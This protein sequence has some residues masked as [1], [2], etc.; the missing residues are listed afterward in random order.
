MDACAA[1]VFPCSQTTIRFI[2]VSSSLPLP[3]LL[4]AVCQVLS[5]FC[6]LSGH[7]LSSV[8][9]PPKHTHKRSEARRTTHTERERERERESQSFSSSFCAFWILTLQ[10]L[11]SVLQSQLNMWTQ[12]SEG[13]KDRE[14]EEERVWKWRGGRSEGGSGQ[15]EIEMKKGLGGESRLDGGRN[16]SGN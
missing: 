9:G 10:G 5:A 16:G 4:C 7:L 1:V 6:L 15:G 8:T 3:L 12:Q 13:E 11:P 14:R 2:S